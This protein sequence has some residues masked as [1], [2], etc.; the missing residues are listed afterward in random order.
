MAGRA[1][2]RMTAEE[3]VD[4]QKSQGDRYELVEGIPLKLMSGSSNY[5]DVLTAN[6]V[7]HPFNELQGKRSRV[8]TADSAAKTRI[9]SYRRP[10]AAVTCDEPKRGSYE[11]E[12]PR[13][14]AEVVSESNTGVQWQRKL[15]E[16]RRREGLAQILLID[17][18]IVSATL[19]TRDGTEWTMTAYDRLSDVIELPMVECRP[20]MAQLY[21]RLDL[22]SAPAPTD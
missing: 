19:L 8:V 14:I 9:N 1:T 10:D 17:S 4:W 12:A 20:A 18:E 7:G 6:V 11:A 13:L 5:H 21:D 16:Y 3:F 2:K 15:D 22:P